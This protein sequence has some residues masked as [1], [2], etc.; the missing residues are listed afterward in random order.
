MTD[1]LLTKTPDELQARLDAARL[2]RRRAVSKESQ[3]RRLVADSDR[4]LAAQRKI[5]LGAA[6]MKAIQGDG[7]PHLDAFKRL[8]S[9]QITRDT[10]RACLVGTVWDLGVGEPSA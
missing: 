5:V 4:R 8:L 2:R 3:I 7:A 10:D 6:L 9:P 1:V